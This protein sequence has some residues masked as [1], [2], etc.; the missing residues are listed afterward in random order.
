MCSFVHQRGN[1]RCPGYRCWSPSLAYHIWCALHWWH[2]PWALWVF[3]PHPCCSWERW[4][5]GC[6]GSPLDLA[7]FL[8]QV[9]SFLCSSPTCLVSPFYLSSCSGNFVSSSVQILL[10]SKW[11]LCVAPMDCIMLL[12]RDM[13]SFLPFLSP[14]LTT[15]WWRYLEA[16]GSQLLCWAYWCPHIPLDSTWWMD[17]TRSKGNHDVSKWAGN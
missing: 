7:F 10:L 12:S 6:C 5:G 2:K 17:C 8:S 3:D 9:P 4:G 16:T 11:S 14:V 1:R 15:H 13:V